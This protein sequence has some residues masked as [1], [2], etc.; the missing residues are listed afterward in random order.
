MFFARHKSKAIYRLWLVMAHGHA[1]KVDLS[2]ESRFIK[3]RN[4][5]EF[6]VVLQKSSLS[7]R[8]TF[9]YLPFSARRCKHSTAPCAGV[10]PFRPPPTVPAR[11]AGCWP[12]RYRS[13]AGCTPSSTAFKT[14]AATGTGRLSA[15]TATRRGSSSSA[16]VALSVW[17]GLEGIRNQY[18]G[19]VC[20]AYLP[21]CCRDNNEKCKTMSGRNR[22]CYTADPIKSKLSQSSKSILSISPLFIHIS[23]S[24]FRMI[25]PVC[26][27]RSILTS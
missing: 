27:A 1:S 20:L 16:R 10:S 9:L 6:V 22:R 11:C 12:S 13:T 3:T 5:M 4:Q 23:L 18:N 19:I 26:E 15:S 17:T 2:M 25:S 24:W 21:R 7:K 8:P 14:T